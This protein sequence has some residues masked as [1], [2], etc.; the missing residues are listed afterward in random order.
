MAILCLGRRTACLA[1]HALTTLVTLMRALNKA[2]YNG[3]DCGW[4]RSIKGD[5]VFLLVAVKS[6]LAPDKFSGPFGHF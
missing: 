3:D 5:V 2:N 6:A 4:Q 1:L